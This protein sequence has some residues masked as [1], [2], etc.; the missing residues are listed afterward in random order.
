MRVM[1]KKQLDDATKK[2]LRAGQM[3]LEGNRPAEV[4]LAVGVARQTVYTWKGLLDDGGLD[5][6]QAV[7]ARGRPARLDQ[8]Q[9]AQ[10]RHALLQSLDLRKHQ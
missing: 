9:L 7:P 1:E 5:A 10:L 8:E 2:R 4:A 3:L 6:L